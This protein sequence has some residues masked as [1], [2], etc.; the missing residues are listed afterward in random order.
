MMWHVC[1]WLRYIPCDT[2]YARHKHVTTCIHPPSETSP[3][4]PL[5]PC[6]LSLPAGWFLRL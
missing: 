1:R 2:Q 3:P 5:P 6:P 4:L